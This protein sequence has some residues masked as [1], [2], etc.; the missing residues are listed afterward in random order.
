MTAVPVSTLPATLIFFYLARNGILLCGVSKGGSCTILN[1]N[2]AALRK[3]RLS[4]DE[5][6]AEEFEGYSERR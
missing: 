4:R 1:A 6:V 5:L 3:E 2:P